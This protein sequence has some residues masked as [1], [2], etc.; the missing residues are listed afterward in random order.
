M[1]T[2]AIKTLYQLVQN[3]MMMAGLS[4]SLSLFLFFS[5]CLYLSFSLSPL[6]SFF[7][8]SFLPFLSFLLSLTYSVPWVWLYNLS[9]LISDQEYVSLI[10]LFHQW[11]AVL[12]H[13]FIHECVLSTMLKT[14]CLGICG[15]VGQAYPNGLCSQLSYMV[16]TLS[17]RNF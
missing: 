3:G 17:L 16:K 5:F 4:V 1:N 15:L 2:V 8:L 7:L 11:L 14:P 10:L 12:I 6:F 9:R 13:L